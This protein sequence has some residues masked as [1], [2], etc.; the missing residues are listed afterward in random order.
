MEKQRCVVAK[1][2]YLQVVFSDSK[3][4]LVIAF[5]KNMGDLCLD[6]AILYIDM[7]FKR[8]NG[9]LNEIII[10]FWDENTF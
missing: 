6:A 8:I 4:Q 3:N 10:C 9:D 2:R 5:N 1:K 7:S